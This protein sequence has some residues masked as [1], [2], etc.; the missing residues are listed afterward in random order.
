MSSPSDVT[1][2]FG[3]THKPFQEDVNFREYPGWVNVYNS[4]GWV[5]DTVET[6]PLH[7]GAVI[8]LDETL[9]SL[10]L[11]MYNEG[12]DPAKYSVCVEEATHGGEDKDPFYKRI[13][14]LLDPNADPWKS[15]S[16]ITAREV[17]IRR[18]NLRAKV[19]EKV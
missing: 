15:F 2:V 4:G 10:S 6:Q 18:Q 3:H 19:N 5:I 16:Q 9:A 14:Q 8:L 11:R 12:A 1:F 7:G 17:R 13:G